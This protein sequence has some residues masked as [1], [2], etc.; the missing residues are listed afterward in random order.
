MTIR[1]LDSIFRAASM[2][3]PPPSFSRWCILA[4]DPN[5]ERG[6][7]ATPV[8]SDLHRRGIGRLVMTRLTDYARARGLSEIF[9]HVLRENVAMLGL[10]RALGLEV[11][12]NR[13][14]PETVLVR[15]RLR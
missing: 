2:T 8:R 12:A 5:N 11:E 7:F 3:E 13:D 10:C 6:E 4:G 15:L 14:A 9:G 1:N